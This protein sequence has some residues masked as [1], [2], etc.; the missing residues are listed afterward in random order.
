MLT[1]F[2]LRTKSVDE[3]STMVK[4]L[5]TDFTKASTI[6][7]FKS[8]GIDMFDASGQLKQADVLLR[9]LNRRFIALGDN[10]KAVVALKNQFTGSEGLIALIN[11]ATDRTGAL[12]STLRSFENS[13]YD[14]DSAIKNMMND[15]VALN[16]ILKNKLGATMVQLGTDTLN[17]RN[18]IMKLGIVILDWVGKQ[19]RD[20]YQW[21]VG[22]KANL[23]K[24]FDY[25]DAQGM[26][27]VEYNAFKRQLE[28]RKEAIGERMRRNTIA[29]GVVW[30]SKR[31]REMLGEQIAHRPVS[32]RT[33]CAAQWHF[34]LRSRCSCCRLGQRC[35]RFRHQR[36]YS[37]N[38]GRG[39]RT[40]DNQCTDRLSDR[41]PDY[42]VDDTSRE[43]AGYHAHGG[44]GYRACCRRC[45][46]DAGHFMIWVRRFS[47]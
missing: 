40:K 44:R 6:K 9:E 42:P 12:E 7:G 29:G 8:A 23:D 19:F 14:E 16:E 33:R 30:D 17:A 3:A 1:L 21:A 28:S 36:R 15:T 27:D 10:S 24:E 22:H 2:T 41:Q 25:V 20:P 34:D 26:T 46:A 11:A 47:I 39:L 32:R 4:S 37:Q 35:F 5:F 31:H 13:V 18:Q 43:P 45:R 38:A